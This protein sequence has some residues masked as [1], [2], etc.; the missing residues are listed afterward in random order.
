MA[1]HHRVGKNR[2]GEEV[3]N[4]RERRVVLMMNDEELNALDS[5]QFEN[6]I[7]TRAKAIREI[8]AKA[9]CNEVKP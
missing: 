6:R 7:P 9:V 3:N 5:Y 2:Y 1:D 4:V 8:V